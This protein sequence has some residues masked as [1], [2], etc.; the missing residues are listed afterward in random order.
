MVGLLKH[1]FVIKL[2]C[3]VIILFFHS[4]CLVSLISCDEGKVSSEGIPELRI[5][6][7]LP[8]NWH[9]AWESIPTL[10]SLTHC[11]YAWELVCHRFLQNR[12]DQQNV[13]IFNKR[14]NKQI[15]KQNVIKQNESEVGK[16]TFPFSDC[17]HTIFYSYLS[18]Q[19]PLKL[20]NLF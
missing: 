18:Q 6:P 12:A 10:P 15:P 19:T 16:I 9:Y 11:H 4:G 20:V 13:C 17:L 3:Y 1:H 7:L 14:T 5:T 2:L 8:P